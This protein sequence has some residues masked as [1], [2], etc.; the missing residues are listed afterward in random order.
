MTRWR[1]VARGV[2]FTVARWLGI[3]ISAV[4]LRLVD[5][6]LRR[7]GYRAVCRWLLRWSPA[8]SRTPDVLRARAFARV[9]NYTAARPHIQANCI[10]RSLVLWWLLR[11][12]RLSSQVR[13]GVNLD[14]G[15]AWVEHG[16]EVVNDAPEVAA[17][18]AILYDD[19]LS[20]ELMSRFKG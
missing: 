11:W 7:S 1:R 13:I 3:G 6:G 14:G 18:Y 2:R 12:A 20:P 8:P 16:G 19:Q 17:Q 10:R 15:H 5:A 9:V 4:L